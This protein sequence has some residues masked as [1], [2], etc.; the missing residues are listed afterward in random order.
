MTSK[1]PKTMRAVGFKRFGAA[2]KNLEAL[3]VPKPTITNPDDILVQVKAA[4]L[5]P[6]D[7]ARPTGVSR[8]IEIV[9]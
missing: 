2:A 8:L 5:N 9:E 4:A 3:E 1:S 6:S 7:S